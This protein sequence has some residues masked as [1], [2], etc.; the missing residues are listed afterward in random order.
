LQDVPI[1]AT[2]SDVVS[3]F[4][5]QEAPAEAAKIQRFLGSLPNFSYHGQHKIYFVENYNEEEQEQQRRWL[6]EVGALDSFSHAASYAQLRERY[7]HSAGGVSNMAT[8]F[9]VVGGAAL[10]A[11]RLRFSV[12]RACTDLFSSMARLRSRR[13]KK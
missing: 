8:G 2:H 10:L 12:V 3:I 7:G 1:V 11:F 9:L 6:S 13:K 4:G 5:E